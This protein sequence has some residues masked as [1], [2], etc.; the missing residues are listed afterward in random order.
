MTEHDSLTDEHDSLIDDDVIAPYSTDPDRSD[1]SR[2]VPEDYEFDIS[3]PEAESDNPDAKDRSARRTSADRPRIIDYAAKKA[4]AS[5]EA[6]KSAIRQ[7]MPYTTVN[8]FL[9]LAVFFTGIVS[10]LS[11]TT[12]RSYGIQTS[13]LSVAILLEISVLLILGYFQ[14]NYTKRFRYALLAC[15][16]I[17]LAEA[18]ILFYFSPLRS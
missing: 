7:N 5:L 11:P 18:G 14:A 4:A 17:T 1:S 12:L 2:L 3:G 13:T 15:G 16:I 10:C 6:E 9:Y 8:I